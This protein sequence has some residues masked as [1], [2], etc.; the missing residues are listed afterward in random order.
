MPYYG[1]GH[2]DIIRYAVPRPLK[3]GGK[4]E[5]ISRMKT[6]HIVKQAARHVD[7]RRDSSSSYLRSW[8]LPA[9]H[10]IFLSIPS[11][12]YNSGWI[13]PTSQKLYKRSPP[14][15]IPSPVSFPFL[16]AP[17]P[18]LTLSLPVPTMPDNTNTA[19]GTSI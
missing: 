16:L 14:L 1:G 4:P 12:P 13:L 19:D 15:L 17:H 11:P 2:F 7:Y 5:S 6:S 10:P 9:F 8:I 18:F 3:L